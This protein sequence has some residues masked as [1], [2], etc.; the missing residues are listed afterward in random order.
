MIPFLMLTRPKKQGVL[1]LLEKH[2]I[3]PDGIEGVRAVLEELGDYREAVE[4]ALQAFVE[5]GD[6]TP[7]GKRLVLT[8]LKGDPPAGDWR[9]KP[10]HPNHSRLKQCTLM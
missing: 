8:R 2:A 5:R 10:R 7:E 3:T 9:T 1:R 4:D 6:L